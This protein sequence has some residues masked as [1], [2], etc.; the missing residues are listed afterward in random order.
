MK[1]REN[2]YSIAVFVLF[3]LVSERPRVVCMCASAKAANRPGKRELPL[4]SYPLLP[5]LSVASIAFLP[6]LKWRIKPRGGAEKTLRRGREG[7]GGFAPQKKGV[8]AANGTYW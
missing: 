3:V 5:S 2:I 4:F 6:S 8:F 1:R 7:K